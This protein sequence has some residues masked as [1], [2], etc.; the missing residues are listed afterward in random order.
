MHTIASSF[1]ADIRSLKMLQDALS[2]PMRKQVA[3]YLA[4]AGELP[5]HVYTSWCILEHMYM[6]LFV[7]EHIFYKPNH[8]CKTVCIDHP[9]EP[10]P[11]A[12][13][14]AGTSTHGIWPSTYWT[15]PSPWRP[16][17]RGPDGAQHRDVDPA[18]LQTPEQDLPTRLCLSLLR[19]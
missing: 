12:E 6:P 19:P 15:W 10:P 3:A 11:A 1:F 7:E 13:P 4:T 8:G 9:C 16:S 18:E 17:D 5:A 14:T 2:M